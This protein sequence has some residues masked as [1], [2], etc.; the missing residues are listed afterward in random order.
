[1]RSTKVQIKGEYAYRPYSIQGG[2]SNL[3]IASALRVQVLSEYPGFV[4]CDHAFRVCV[5]DDMTGAPATFAN[6]DPRCMVAAARELQHTWTE[7]LHKF[8]P[9]QVAA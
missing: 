2:P 1:M 7:H 3:P 9:G 8:F 5:L 4:G 6:G